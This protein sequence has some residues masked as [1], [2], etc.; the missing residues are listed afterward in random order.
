MFVSDAAKFEAAAKGTWSADTTSQGGFRRYAVSKLFLIMIQHELQERLNVDAVFNKV[1]VLGCD[2]STIIS[3]I[4]RL[5]PWL[6]R[7]F[8]FKMIYPVLLRVI[9]KRPVRPTSAA[10]DD[11][12]E[13]AFGRAEEE[14]L[15]KDR[16]FNGRKP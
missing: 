13:A 7:V 15:P 14:G 10:A 9:P 11:V 2:P 5:A 16:Y 12:L 8:A 1:S 4:V 3:G 6:I